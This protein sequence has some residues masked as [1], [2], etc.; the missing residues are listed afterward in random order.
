MKK[1]LAIFTTISIALFALFTV[2]NFSI[3]ESQT[4]YSSAKTYVDN[5]QG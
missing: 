1:Y 3:S 2:A 5:P 4:I